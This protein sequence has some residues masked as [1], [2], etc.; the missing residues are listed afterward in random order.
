MGLSAQEPSQGVPAAPGTVV[1]EFLK[2]QER[3]IVWLHHFFPGVD[4]TSFRAIA[5]VCIIAVALVLRGLGARAVLSRI[6]RWTGKAEAGLKGRVFAG[7]VGPAG[8]L[9][10]VC[11]IYVAL[12]VFHLPPEADRLVAA[13]AKV[14]AR[15]MLLWGVFEAGAAMLS[16]FEQTARGRG[17]VTFMPLIRRTLAVVFGILASLVLADSLGVNVGTYL[18]GL[19]IGGLGLALGAQETLANMFGSLSVALDRPFRIGD[20]VRIG[21]YEGTVEDIGLRS[22]RLRLG[23]RSQVAMPNKLVA[24]ETIRNLSRMPQRLAEQKVRLAHDTTPDQVEAI[25]ADIRKLLRSDPAVVADTVA[26]NF[27]SIG[28]SSLDVNVGYFTADPD[29]QR[30]LDVRERINLAIIRAVAARNIRFA[31]PTQAI[32]QEPSR[33]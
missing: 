6:Q 8:G 28:D 29:L 33:G 2:L 32:V 15:A 19:G 30:H 11:G 3:G 20:L 16:H 12:S 9:L 21:D 22:T 31:L 7:L 14:A 5:A 27:V 18:T 23:D 10:M 17:I 4:E 26:V 24:S 1:S 13:G 25:L